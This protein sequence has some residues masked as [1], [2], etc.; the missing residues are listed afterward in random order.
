MKILI[1]EDNLRLQ[2]S[3]GML[4]KC[5]GFDFDTANNG[6][7]AVERAV[8]NEGK[9]DLC[10]MDIDMPIMNGCEAARAIR[11]E[12]KYFPIMALS[13][14]ACIEEKYAAAGMDDYL[15]KPFEADRLLGKINELTIKSLKIS[16]RKNDL[17]FIKEM[18]M[19]AAELK[20]LRELDKKGLAKFSLIDAD[21][22]FIAH[23]NLQNK[24][25]HDFIAKGKLLS[26]FLDR[27]EDDP[28]I[29][30]LY[31]SNLHANKKHILPETFQEL[32]LLEDEEFRNY[33]T[34][35]EYPEKEGP[36]SK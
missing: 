31:S 20:E 27:S 1:A 13:G 22:K 15:P 21:H 35:S 3:V 12:L 8:A 5:W 26:E 6:Q 34:K 9:Y 4:L 7:E 17:H 33:T 16:F 23:K 29:I 14:N 36:D 28:G 25:S 24:V 10:L 32:A 30:H 18:P 19:D 2:K 11:R